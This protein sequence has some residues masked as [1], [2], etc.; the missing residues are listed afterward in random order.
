MS[1]KSRANAA[2]IEVAKRRERATALYSA[3]LDMDALE[4]Y[5]PG[6][7]QPLEAVAVASEGLDQAREALQAAVGAAH[8][9]GFSWTLI[10]ETLGISRQAARQRFGGQPTT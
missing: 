3:R 6:T 2:R 10:G 1:K 8:A 4:A 9:A 5:R 7:R